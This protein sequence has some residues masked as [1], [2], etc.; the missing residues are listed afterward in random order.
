MKSHHI[1]AYLFVYCFLSEKIIACVLAKS[2]RKK[3]NKNIYALQTLP[4]VIHDTYL[5]LHSQTSH[6]HVLRLFV[7]S[8]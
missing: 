7:R 8:S 5:L 2:R 4:T 1:Y 3:N 6:R